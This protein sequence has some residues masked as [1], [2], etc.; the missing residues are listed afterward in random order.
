VKVVGQPN[1]ASPS[2]SSW[3]RYNDSEWAYPPKAAAST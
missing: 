2:V 1:P 3:V